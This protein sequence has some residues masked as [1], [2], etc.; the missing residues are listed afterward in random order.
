M[1]EFETQSVMGYRDGK[2]L[3]RLPEDKDVQYEE[4]VLHLY[5]RRLISQLPSE[6]EELDTGLPLFPG[7]YNTWAE[8]S[9][10]GLREAAAAAVCQYLFDDADH[11]ALDAVKE[12]DLHLYT[13]FD[14]ASYER[15]VS[16]ECIE[17]ANNA[18]KM[19]GSVGIRMKFKGVDSPRE[20][21]F[22]NDIVDVSVEVDNWQ[23]YVMAV[24]NYLF[25]PDAKAFD[26]FADYIKKIG[27][28]RDGYIAFYSSELEEWLAELVLDR[29]EYAQHRIIL[30]FLLRECLGFTEEHMMYS[31]ESTGSLEKYTLVNTKRM[32]PESQAAKLRDTIEKIENDLER[33]LTVNSGVERRNRYIRQA[34]QA[35]L[36]ALED[37]MGACIAR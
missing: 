22:K 37:Y 12:M 24:Y 35:K 32:P 8:P 36:E 18:F 34:R 3:D 20:Y 16:A 15:D 4:D 2:G 19:I 9:D 10:E 29:L 14:M 1:Y 23:A 11:A 31:V 7:F 33:L 17:A 30:D 13:D 5:C 26:H 25:N 28:S 6:K 21:N 27:T